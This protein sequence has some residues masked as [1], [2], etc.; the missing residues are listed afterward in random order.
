MSTSATTYAALVCAAALSSGCVP[1]AWNERADFPTAQGQDPAP[2]PPADDPLTGAQASPAAPAAAETVPQA[3]PVSMDSANPAAI[4]SGDEVPIGEEPPAPDAA[5]QYQE[6]DPSALTDFRSALEPYGTWEDDA[7]YGTVWYPSPS[8]V[9]ADFTPYSTGGHWSYDGY[10][11]VWVSDY[12]WG[13]GPFHYGR[14]TYIAGHGWGWVP[15]RVYRGAWVNWRVGPTGYG[16]IGWAPMAPTWYW[17]HGYAYGVSIVPYAP[18]SFC[19][20]RDLFHPQVGGRVIRGSSVADV[21]RNTR[22]YVEATPGIGGGSARA[23]ASPGIGPENTGRPRETTTSAA[24][25]PSPAS[26]GVGSGQIVKTPNDQAGI[27]RAKHF[28]D[29]KMR[30]QLGL[31]PVPPHQQ[32]QM[33]RRVSPETFDAPRRPGGSIGVRP[34]SYRPSP[35]PSVQPSSPPTSYDPSPRFRPSTPSARAPSSPGFRP[36]TPNIRPSSPSVRPSTPSFRPSTPSFRPSTP[37]FRPSTPSFRP[38][39]PSFRPST[40]S[41]R[42]STPSRPSRGGRR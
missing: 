39:T 10:E 17:Y 7:L 12:E 18:Y 30:S 11:Y 2:T 42:P 9:G 41:F 21:A 25:A 34:P 35:R 22:P 4:A 6:T 32:P 5:A 40:P 29:P 38:S 8:Q 20:T 37:S 27:S 23:N 19:A 13:W 28:G 24:Y 26:I 14:W 33:V 15:G 3:A 1:D 16:Y 36:S 31:R